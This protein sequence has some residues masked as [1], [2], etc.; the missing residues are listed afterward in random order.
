MKK[1]NVLLIAVLLASVVSMGC[2]KTM[3]QPSREDIADTIKQHLVDQDIHCKNV[4][5]VKTDSFHYDGYC[6]VLIL[7]SISDPYYVQH[8]VI[9]TLDRN[10]PS[11]YIYTVY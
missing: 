11:Q 3:P 4:A 5:L 8:R 7:S 9:V 2:K 1:I 6:N 10:D